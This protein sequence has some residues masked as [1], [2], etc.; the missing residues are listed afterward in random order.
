M[1]LLKIYEEDQCI[2]K[3]I[4]WYPCIVGRSLHSDISIGHMSVSGRHAIIEAF[5]DHFVLRDLGSSNGL[6]HNGIKVES[7]ALKKNETLWIGD[8]K[9]EVVFDE[10]LP[11]TSPGQDLGKSPSHGSLREISGAVSILLMGYVA[12]LSLVLYQ[13]YGRVWPPDTVYPLFG[14]AFLLWAAGAGFAGILA[15]FS[16]INVQK[17]YFKKISLFVFLF[18]F[19]AYSVALNINT[20]IF[21]LRS[22]PGS[23]FLEIVL[24][25]VLAVSFVT[26]VM[27]LILANLS[28]RVRILVGAILSI[29][30]V[31]LMRWMQADRSDSSGRTL[32]TPLGVALVDPAIA[33]DYDSEDLRG[34][35]FRTIA[36]VDGERARI[37][38]RRGRAIVEPPRTSVEDEGEQVEDEQPTDQE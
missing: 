29:S 26:S 23:S 22:F 27:R 5:E 16:K 11:K 19:L 1:I 13:A 8:V 33:I 30:A 9:I 25:F 31:F 35:F 18:G 10:G 21:N 32:V 34:F 2:L 14:K 36:E 7:L 6:F 17:Y 38:E 20:I 37:L 24:Y 4:N 12:T 28:D 3:K 15:L